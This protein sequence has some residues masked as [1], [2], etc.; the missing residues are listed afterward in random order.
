MKKTKEHR[1]EA[2]LEPVRKEVEVRRSPADAFRMFT[3]ELSSWWPL[4]T[5]SVCREKA[6]RCAFEG[7]VGGE[8]YEE[9]TQGGRH[10][11]GTVSV[12]EVPHRLAFTWH[13]GRGAETAQQVELRF[14]AT[15]TGTLVE[16]EHRG[17]EVLGDKATETRQG[18]DSGWEILFVE[19]FGAYC[20]KEV[21]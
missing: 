16:L 19:T 6:V 10:V 15:E 3:E 11:W 2:C 21:S 7:R 5:H 20:N 4:A 9:D 13:P 14:R 18:Y 8:L 12:W 17:W 1:P